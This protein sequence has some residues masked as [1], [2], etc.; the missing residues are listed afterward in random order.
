MYVYPPGSGFNG[1]PQLVQPGD[2]LFI[3]ETSP[4]SDNASERRSNLDVDS[5]VITEFVPTQEPIASVR[6]FKTP[7]EDDR[8]E[9]LSHKN[10]SADTMKKVK[11]VLKMYREWRSFRHAGG[12]QFIACDLDDKSTIT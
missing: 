6:Q 1:L 8:L 11:W 10:F 9:E 2:E 12:Y 5:D 4:S 7:L 3:Q